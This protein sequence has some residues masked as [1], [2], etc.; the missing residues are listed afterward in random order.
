MPLKR[1]TRLAQFFLLASA[2]N[3][4][5][6]QTVTPAREH[7]YLGG[8]VIAVEN[9]TGGGG[10]AGAQIAVWPTTIS[11]APSQS[12][13]FYAAVQ[14]GTGTVIWSVS[15]NG[16]GISQAGVYTAPAT[17]GATQA[18]V[19]A[20]LSGTT[21]SA[22]ATV[23]FYG[24]TTSG[25]YPLLGSFVSFDRDQSAAQW[26]AELNHMKSLGMNTLVLLSAGSLQPDSSDPTGYSLSGVGLLYPSSLVDASVRPATDRLE[27]ILN[28]ADLLQMKVYVGSLQTAQAWD[29]GLE[30]GALN[31][32]NRLA[33][34]EIIQKYAQHPSLAGWYFTQEIWLNWVKFYYGSVGSYYGVGLLQQ[35]V[36]DMRSVDPSK[37]VAAAIVFKK[38]P[39]WSMPGL[40]AG[41]IPFWTTTLLQGTGLQILMPQ[42]GAGAEAGAADVS[43]LGAYFQAFQAGVAA[44]GAAV[45]W[46]TV[47]TF[48]AETNLPNDQ[49]P[50]APATRIQQQI[51]N[52]RPYVSGFVSWIFG[53]DMS[54]QATYYP[55]EASGLTRD[56]Q[57]AFQPGTIPHSTAVSY[58]SAA[59]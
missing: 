58:A 20:T 56:Y 31:K 23:I 32:Y 36:S 54:S 14:G 1:I 40:T 11:L 8:R 52:E 43:E 29:T 44:A 7:I 42:D 21:R 25:T 19:T 9:P 4:G 38:S 47:E 51:Q 28:M 6:A 33:G 2:L 45:L 35:Y 46:S 13:Q 53:H 16:G 48:T 26:S 30:F 10:G 37:P 12:Q 55:V 18:T 59:T 34:Q 24:S 49:Y 41:E 57:A 3:S 17:P 22:S 15:S 5:A 50:P 27:M 39:Y